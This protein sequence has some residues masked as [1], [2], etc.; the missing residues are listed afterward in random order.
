MLALAVVLAALGGWWWH[1]RSTQPAAGGAEP[2]ARA[3][4]A[5]GGPGGANRRFGAGVQPVS[6]QPAEL[7]DIRVVVDAIGSISASNT[8]VVRAQVAGVLQSL[9]FKEGQQVK[10][11]QVIAQIDPRAFRAALGQ[12]EGTLARDRAQLENARIDLAR[13]RDLLAKDA[14]A[15]Q[16]LDTQEALVRQLEGTVQ[17]DRAAVE[18]ARLQLSYTRV[19]APISG[20]VGLKQADLGNLVQTGDA[21]GLVTITQTQ[22]IALVFAV[23]SAHLPQITAKLRANEP[24]V[25]EAWDRGGAQRLALGR[26][27]TIDNAIDPATDTIKAKAEFANRDEALFPNQSVSVKLELDTQENAL[28]VPPAAVLRGARGFYVYVVGADGTVSTRVVKTGAVDGD[29]MAVSGALQAG[30]RVV[31]DGV[32]RLREGAKVEVI[33]SDPRLRAGASEPPGGGRRGPPGAAP[34]AGAAPGPDAASRPYRR[35]SAPFEAG[36]AP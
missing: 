22:P 28:A 26:L 17:T 2:G 10:A 11:G 21:N 9:S 33:A 30:E 15:K 29:W 35:A 16:Q 4:G 31:I 24:L 5:G 32:D 23:P 34:A 7:R 1:A 27:A 6:V 18:T 13:Y 12:A 8:A 19:V 14:I 36:R 3:G 25:V 20:R